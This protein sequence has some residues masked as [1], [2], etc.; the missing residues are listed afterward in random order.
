MIQ[1]MVAILQDDLPYIV[2]TYD[3]NLEAYNSDALS[4]VERSVPGGDRRHALRAGLLRA[5]AD[6]RSR[7][8]GGGGDETVSGV[9][10]GVAAIGAL[11]VAVGGVPVRR[12][13][14]GAARPSRWSSRRDGGDGA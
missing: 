5:A 14:A 11:I 2:L 10:G 13:P 3:P 6:A 7:G 1:E 8:E 12:A 9:P 4:N